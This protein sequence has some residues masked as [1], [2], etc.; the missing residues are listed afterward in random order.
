MYAK[1]FESYLK[2]YDQNI[3]EYIC[4]YP[5]CLLQELACLNPTTFLPVYSLCNI[6][7]YH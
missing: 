7:W 3:K 2:L 1:V 4:Y 6:Y 5:V